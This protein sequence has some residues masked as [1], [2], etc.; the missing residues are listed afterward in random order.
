MNTDE[1]S[2]QAG[3]WKVTYNAKFTLSFC[4]LALF[5]TFCGGVAICRFT[6][7][8]SVFDCFGVF[9]KGLFRGAGGSGE[10]T[11]ITTFP[12]SPFPFF[13]SSRV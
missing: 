9:E 7:C 3:T 5:C 10:I 11:V 8:V 4:L 2:K 12:D 1:H 13:V 6:F